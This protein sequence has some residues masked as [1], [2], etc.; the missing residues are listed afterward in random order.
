VR[1]YATGTYGAS[2]YFFSKLVTEL[3]LSLCTSFLSFLI[4]YWM[5]GLRGPFILHVLITWLVGLAS[6]STAL[7]FS[8]V[9]SSAQEAVQAAPAIFMPQV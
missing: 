7:L 1:E 8:C 6:A 9:A 3:P 2:P 4:V 5:V